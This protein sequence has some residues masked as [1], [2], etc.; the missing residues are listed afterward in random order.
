M[1]RIFLFIV[2]SVDELI[3]NHDPVG[4]FDDYIDVR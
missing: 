2:E 3:M 1:N 4:I